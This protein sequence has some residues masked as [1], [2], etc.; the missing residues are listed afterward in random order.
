M[1][2]VRSHTSTSTATLTTENQHTPSQDIESNDRTGHVTL[3]QNNGREQIIS[4]ETSTILNT[5]HVH[6]YENNVS[7]QVHQSNNSF[8]GRIHHHDRSSFSRVTE[9]SNNLTGQ[10]NPQLSGHN[11]ISSK[12]NIH[13]LSTS[14]ISNAGLTHLQLPPPPRHSNVKINKQINS[15]Q[16]N[17]FARVPTAHAG[18]P[19]NF[20]ARLNKPPDEH[21]LDNNPRNEKPPEPLQVNEKDDSNAWKTSV[22]QPGGETVKDLQEKSSEM[23]PLKTDSVVIK[24]F[25]KKGPVPKFIPRQ[26]QSKMKSAEKLS[27]TKEQKTSANDGDEISKELRRNAFTL[28]EIQGPEDVIEAKRKEP[29]L[30]IASVAKSVKEIRKHVSQVL[31]HLIHYRMTNFRLF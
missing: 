8:L 27:D 6:Q 2:R 18:F 11:G 22:K 1:G 14:T 17:R 25:S 9:V 21:C 20:D 5:R 30:Q 19:S 28:R 15:D 10:L 12:S 16:C 7:S 26:M 29:V 4:N 3:I 23:S 31:S 13:G 24:N